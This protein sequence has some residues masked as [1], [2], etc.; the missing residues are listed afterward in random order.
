M[1]LVSRKCG[2]FDV[3]QSC[4]P[5]KPGCKDIFLSFFL[6]LSF[7][8]QSVTWDAFSVKLSE[9]YTDFQITHVINFLLLFPFLNVLPLSPGSYSPTGGS[10][11]RVSQGA[12]LC[13]CYNSSFLSQGRVFSVPRFCEVYILTDFVSNSESENAAIGCHIAGFTV[14]FISVGVFPLRRG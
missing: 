14:P 10:R 5:P 13:R 3:S 12:W 7:F 2:S 11:N 1:S 4:R 9:L 8:F 6:F